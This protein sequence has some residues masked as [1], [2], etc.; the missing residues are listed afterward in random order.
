MIEIEEFRDIPGY[1]G[2]YEVS[3][4]GRVRSLETERILKPSKNTWGYL[5]VSLYK[6]GIKKAVRIH[7]LV[8]LAFIPNPDNLPCINHKDEDK[9]N[10]T[11]DNLEWC[12]DKYN[13]NYG[14]RNERIAEK[15]R[16][17]VL[18][19]DLLGNFIREWPSITKVEEETGIWQTHISKCCLGLRHTAGGYLWKYKN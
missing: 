17:P 3:N 16:K 2:L 15:T 5:F 14:T 12:D 6:N 7:R 9:T 1:E 19:Y 13:A 11:V 8:A 10:N 4:L 18:Q